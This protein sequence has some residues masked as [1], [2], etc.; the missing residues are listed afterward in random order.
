LAW[1]FF[2]G[3]F[4]F[5]KT[6]LALVGCRVLIHAKPVTQRSWDLRAKDGF[7]IGPA[8]G[9][10]RCF[11]LVKSNT[12]S[13]V[14]SDTVEFCHAFCSIPAPTPDDKI[15]HGL[16]V[17]SGALT[18]APPPR[19]ISQLEA[20]VNLRDLFKSW[21]LLG[22]PSSGQGRIKSPGRPRVSIQEP[23]RVT[24]PSSPMVVPPPWTAW[25][26]PP[27]LVSSTQVPL[28][29]HSPIQVTPRHI[30]FDDTPPPR[31]ATSPSTPRAVIKPRPPCNLPSLTGPGL[32]PK[33]PLPSLQAAA[34]AAMAFPTT[35]LRL[36][37][38]VFLKNLWALQAFVKLSP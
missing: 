37:P 29:V 22:L 20:I 13:Q 33:L 11:K 5:N 34:P 18:N 9:S 10:Y 12:K 19:S 17:M 3:P 21:R 16:Q 8:L 4:D 27:R 35:F 30:T 32:A 38:H 1:E 24:S 31:V 28:P 25:T 23:P 7:Y 26:P 36:K 15:I 2:H 6:P 14:I